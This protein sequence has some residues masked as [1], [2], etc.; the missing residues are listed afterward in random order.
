MNE[1][2]NA[3]YIMSKPSGSEILE[4]LEHRKND[5]I[6]FLRELTLA[7]S[8]SLV[9]ESQSYAREIISERL[10][11]IGY[12]TLRLSGNIH[13]GHLFARPHTRQ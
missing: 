5:F 10:E 7:E 4:Y 2:D 11:M 13:G 9:P 3:V 12:R 1:L 6:A 8:P